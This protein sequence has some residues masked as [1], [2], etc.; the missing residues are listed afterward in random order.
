MSCEFFVKLTSLFIFVRFTHTQFIQD[1]QSL[2]ARSLKVNESE[3][4][5]RSVW[6]Q[7]KRCWRFFVSS[8]RWADCLSN[9]HRLPASISAAYCRLKD[10]L[11]TFS[12]LLSFHCVIEFTGDS[13]NIR[14]K[15]AEQRVQ[16]VFSFPK[17][18]RRR[19]WWK[20]IFS[21]EYFG[22]FVNRSDADKFV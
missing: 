9:I 3:F 1:F 16:T 5:A 20:R 18:L 17:S 8:R 21:K 4:D 10:Q 19:G 12:K 6:F 22:S 14:S 2:T 13:C 11:L 7:P 15:C